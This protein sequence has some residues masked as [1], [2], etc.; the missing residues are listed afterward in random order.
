MSYDLISLINVPLLDD[1]MS[2]CYGN[3]NEASIFALD[4]PDVIL[5]SIGFKRFLNW[6][7]L[8]TIEINK[9]INDLVAKW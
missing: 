9:L 8:V 4:C 7:L 2:T 6:W 1:M 3:T 5:I